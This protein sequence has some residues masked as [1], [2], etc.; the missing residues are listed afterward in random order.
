MCPYWFFFVWIESSPYVDGDEDERDDD[1][2]GRERR[3]RGLRMP[4]LLRLLY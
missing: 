2:G 1:D 3:G 4:F